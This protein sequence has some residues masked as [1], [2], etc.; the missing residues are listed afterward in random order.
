MKAV[1]KVCQNGKD[2]SIWKNISNTRWYFFISQA[3]YVRV[4]TQSL[5]VLLIWY[6]DE[7]ACPRGWLQIPVSRF[8][9][10][11]W[12]CYDRRAAAQ[13]L[14]EVW[15][16]LVSPYLN[17]RSIPGLLGSLI[18]RH[19]ER[20]ANLHPS[21]QCC[22]CSPL[23]IRVTHVQA[24]GHQQEIGILWVVMTPDP[25]L[26]MVYLPCQCRIFLQGCLYWAVPGNV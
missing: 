20:G 21:S 10:I 25:L 6:G 3:A 18:S 19:L 5:Q 14:L 4:V 17:E 13:L 22:A 9:S 23:R 11:S 26:E 8:S 1:E 7:H 12:R 15:N 16:N 2:T 24:I